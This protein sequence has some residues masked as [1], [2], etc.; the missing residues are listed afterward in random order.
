[1][2]HKLFLDIH[3]IQTLPPSNINRDDT[4]SPKTAQYGGVRRARVSSQAWKRAM[5]LYFAE[6][7]DAEVGVRTKDIVSYVAN[8]I[9]KQKPEIAS[10]NAFEMAKKTIKKA[11]IT[12]GTDDKAKALFF[13]GKTQAEKLADAAI[14]NN[15]DKKA[16]QQV[17]KSNPAVD[18]ALFGRML[19]NK[20]NGITLNEDAS[21]QVVHA[22][23]T[24]G[25][26]TE[27]DYYTAVDD[28]A[29]EDNAGAGMLGTVEY[30]SSTLYRYA[31]VAVH[32]LLRQLGDADVTVSTLKLFIEAFANS[33]PT[34]KINTFANQTVPQAIMINIRDDRPVNL[35]SAYETPVKSSE[36][37]VKPSIDRM[38][39]E[40][41]KT[42]KFVHKPLHTLYVADEENLTADGEKEESLSA[43]L[44]DFGEEIRRYL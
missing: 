44:K 10:Q 28:L 37:F 43:L 35:V 30:N 4:G 42:E 33:L 6:N 3:A 13:I 20:E 32:E 36:G 31:N 17:L 1:M 39:A 9:K 14:S 25:V 2:S 7:S 27:F 41:K 15:K 21:A 19:A 16:L 5:R 29:A 40:L 18:I 26:Q 23:S 34:G 11:G 24:H 12:I 22:I 38:F 8:F